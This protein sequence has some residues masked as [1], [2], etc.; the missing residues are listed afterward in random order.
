MKFSRLTTQIQQIVKCGCIC[1]IC[2]F[3]SSPASCNYFK[4]NPRHS[5]YVS[6]ILPHASLKHV[7]FFLYNHNTI[8]TLNKINDNSWVSLNKP[9]CDNIFWN[10]FKMSFTDALFQSTHREGSLHLVVMFLKGFNLQPAALLLPLPPTPHPHRQFH[11]HQGHG[12]GCP[13]KVP[14]FWICL[15]LSLFALEALLDSVSTSCVWGEARILHSG[16]LW[17]ILHHF[18][19]RSVWLSYF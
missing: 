2:L 3:F 6:Y 9:I 18:R 19:T 11:P 10:I 1:F 15:F 13:I 5:A 8:V 4:A 14:T 12:V 16:A 7:D 17:F